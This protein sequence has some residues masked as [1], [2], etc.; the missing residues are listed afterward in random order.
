MIDQPPA[1]MVCGWIG[2]QVAGLVSACL[3]RVGERSVFQRTCQTVFYVLLTLVGLTTV[4]AVSCVPQSG[5]LS[6]ATLAVMVLA[7]VWDFGAVH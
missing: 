2:L 7:A 6:G 3:A 4:A 1:A 5:M